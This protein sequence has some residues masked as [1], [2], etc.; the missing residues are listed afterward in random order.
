MN[1]SRRT[2]VASTVIALFSAATYLLAWSPIFEVSTITVKGNPKEV[3][4]QVIVKA[5]DISVG[6]KLSRIEPRSIDNRLA[7]LN[8]IESA[9]LSRNWISGEITIVVKPRVAVGLYKGRALD[10]SGEIFDLPGDAPSQLP[11]VTAA[12]ADLGLEAIELFRELPLSIRENLI[13]ISASNQSSIWSVEM[14][15]NRRLLVQWGSLKELALKVR[16]YNALLELPENKSAKKIDL[17]APHA[18]I[19]K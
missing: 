13:S 6:D 11:V 1:L 10:S 3:A 4:T 2:L 16:V 14:R 9:D 17:S 7:E 12:S 18:P 5:S 15:E 19:V 8:W